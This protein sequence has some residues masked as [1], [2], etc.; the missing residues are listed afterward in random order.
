MIAK[1]NNGVISYVPKKYTFAN[2]D[3]EMMKTY[4]GYKD[5]IENDK[6]SYNLETQIVVPVY[7]ET[8]TQIVCNWEV[9]DITKEE[10]EEQMSGM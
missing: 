4:A 3:P 2:P 6:P 10:M 9:R 5:Y 7:S 1:L 8:E